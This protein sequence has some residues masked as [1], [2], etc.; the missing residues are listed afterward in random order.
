VR[1]VADC[2][3]S[4]GAKFVAGDRLLDAAA[5]GPRWLQKPEIAQSVVHVLREGEKFMRYELRAWVVMPNHVHIVL[6]PAIDLSK[7]VAA[8]KASGARDAN[9]L[10]TRSGERFWARDYFDRW[11]RNVD[12]EQRIVRYIERNPVKAGLCKSSEDW[13]WSSANQAFRK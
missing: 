2:W 13:P 1:A 12:E 10:L 6:R 4:D 9:C 11:I 3:T 5:T 7:I 8:I